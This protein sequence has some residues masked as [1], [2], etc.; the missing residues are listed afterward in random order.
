MSTYIF[1]L[2]RIYKNS[3]K[4]HWVNRQKSRVSVT[5]QMSQ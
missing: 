1:I 2:K 5:T 3:I 4:F